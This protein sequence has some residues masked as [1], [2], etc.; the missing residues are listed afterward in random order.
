MCDF[1]AITNAWL[2]RAIAWHQNVSSL[3][4]LAQQLAACRDISSYL[5]QLAAYIQN[6]V[7]ERVFRELSIAF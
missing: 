3:H 6:H 2:A 7:S 5:A 1:S 4:S